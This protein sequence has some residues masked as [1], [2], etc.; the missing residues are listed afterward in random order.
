LSGP[1]ASEFVVAGH[2]CTTAIAPG[3]SCT[4][5]V[6]FDPSTTGTKNATLSQNPAGTPGVSA[7][8]AGSGSFF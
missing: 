4:M 6:R 2:T 1:D 7:T 8:L 3:A 5:T